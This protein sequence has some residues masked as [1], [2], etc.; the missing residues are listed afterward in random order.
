MENNSN[1]M[2]KKYII[3]FLFNAT[4]IESLPCPF[5][6]IIL[7]MEDMSLWIPQLRKDSRHTV[8]ALD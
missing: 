6:L 2:R 5:T 4:F 3:Q 8:P 7:G 1:K